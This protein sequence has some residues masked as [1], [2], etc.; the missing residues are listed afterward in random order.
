LRRRDRLVSDV[1]EREAE[2]VLQPAVLAHFEVGGGQTL[3]DRAGSIADDHVDRNNIA[4]GAEHGPRLRRLLLL[5]PWSGDQETR[6]GG[7][8]G[9]RTRPAHVRT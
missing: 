1:L 7:G 4:R 9:C 8:D 2:D 3:Y 6:E 5:R